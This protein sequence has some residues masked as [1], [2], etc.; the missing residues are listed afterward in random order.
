[1]TWEDFKWEVNY[2]VVTK[3]YTLYRTVTQSV[4]QLIVWFKIIW[5][6][7]EWDHTYLYQIQKFKLERMKHEL[8]TN[9]NSDHTINIRDIKTCIILI[10]R[11]IED[12]FMGK[13]SD[14]GS[15]WNMKVKFWDYEQ[16]LKQKHLNLLYKIMAKRSM[17]WWD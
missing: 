6:N 17:R 12:D 8:E 1:M 9:G 2:Y 3:P 11:I 5:N 15:N 4:K 7:R 14:Y 10:D 16:K 13:S